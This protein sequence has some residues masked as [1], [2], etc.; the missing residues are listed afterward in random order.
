MIVATKSSKANGSRRQWTLADDKSPPVEDKKQRKLRLHRQEMVQYRQR[1]KLRETSLRSQH[2]QLERQLQ[3]QVADWRFQCSQIPK[4]AVQDTQVQK[5]QSKVRELVLSG[6]MLRV[7]NE[8]LEKVVSERM[9]TQKMVFAEGDRLVVDGVNT[10]LNGDGWRVR[11]DNGAPSFHFHPF[12]ESECTAIVEKYDGIL[13]ESMS[14]EDIGYLLGW[15]VERVPLKPHDKG[16]WMITRVRFSKRVH[17]AAGTSSA[18]MDQ[19]DQTSWPVLTTPE[20]CQ[21]VHRANVTSQKLQEFGGDTVVTV[22]NIPQNSGLGLHLRYLNVLH[23]RRMIHDNGRR[24]ISYAIVIPDS[25]ANKRSREAELSRREVHWVCEGG[26]FITLTQLDHSTLEV[27]Y[28]S[29][30]GCRNEL[31]AQ[32]LLIEW[33]HEAVRWEELVTPARLLAM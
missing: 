30:S 6:E 11:F 2:Q 19:L 13:Q 20:F 22:S 26:A 33:G 8:R 28:D 14:F 18:T 23:R 32:Q 5:L 3:K 17:C 1:K 21:R 31:H 4:V 15:R 24:T 16:K 29:T 9:K 12:S 10:V 7:E 25:V 27:I